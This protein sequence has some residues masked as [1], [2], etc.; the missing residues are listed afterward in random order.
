MRRRDERGLSGSVQAA[1]LFPLILLPLLLGLQWALHSWA[2]ATAL[3]AAQDAARASAAFGATIADGEAAAR[4]ALD[5]ASTT[6]QQIHITRG[7]TSTQ[8][9]VRVEAMTVVPLWDATI[10]IS[11]TAPTQRITQS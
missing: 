4:L 5:N 7:A 8:A 3:A 9:T 1:L 2:N 6:S 11:A 10:T